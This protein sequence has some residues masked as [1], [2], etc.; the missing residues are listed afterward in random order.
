MC[1]ER[2][3]AGEFGQKETSGR[4]DEII[5]KDVGKSAKIAE[6]L[7]KELKIEK[8]NVNNKRKKEKCI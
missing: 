8:K 1:L 4:S 7:L 5:D 2:E 3:R 6:I